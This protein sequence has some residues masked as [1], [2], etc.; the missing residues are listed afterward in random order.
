VSDFH[1]YISDTWRF[2]LFPHSVCHAQA[3]FTK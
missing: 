3:L 2:P 1:W